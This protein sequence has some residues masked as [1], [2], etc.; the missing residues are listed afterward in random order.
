[1][2]FFFSIAI[3][4]FLSF[5]CLSTLHSFT[6]SLLS[7]SSLACTDDVYFSSSIMLSFFS[8]TSFLPTAPSSTSFPS[9]S[10]SS[11]KFSSGHSVLSSFPFP[12]PFL[13]LQSHT[14]KFGF[15]PFNNLPFLPLPLFFPPANT[16]FPTVSLLNFPSF[17]SLL[18]LLPSPPAPPRLQVPIFL[19]RW[20]IHHANARVFTLLASHN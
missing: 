1:M 5:P 10:G 2:F 11:Y 8:T 3:S 4:L 9:P 15:Y 19:C 13:L 16:C 12:L 20:N 6:P 7:A 17:P 18:R 14:C